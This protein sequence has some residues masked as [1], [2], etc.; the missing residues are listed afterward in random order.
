MQAEYWQGLHWYI[1]RM[2]TTGQSVLSPFRSFLFRPRDFLSLFLGFLGRDYESGIVG[3]GSL[4]P[5]GVF[6]AF[7]RCFRSPFRAQPRIPRLRAGKSWKWC[8][9]CVCGSVPFLW[10]AG[11]SVAPCIRAAHH[12]PALP[13]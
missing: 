5:L 1:L 6:C 2:R 13:S 10:S 11:G 8:F 3:A 12:S 9:H 7:L 4:E